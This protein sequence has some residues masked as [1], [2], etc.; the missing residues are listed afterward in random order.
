MASVSGIVQ[1][2]RYVEVTV[3]LD[4]NPGMTSLE[5]EFDFDSTVLELVGFVSPHSFFNG[6]TDTGV[7]QWDWG[8]G[9]ARLQ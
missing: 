2:G 6:D 9:L 4:E 3:S 1:T 7:A 5:L 8:M